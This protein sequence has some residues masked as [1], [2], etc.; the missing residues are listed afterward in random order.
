[1]AL[2]LTPALGDCL[3]RSNCIDYRRDYG[4]TTRSLRC[5]SRLKE[6][7]RQFDAGEDMQPG[8]ILI[9]REEQWA[10]YEPYEP[11]ESADAS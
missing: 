2:C 11:E 5:K 3:A 7:V 9:N 1:V 8:T 4:Y 10:D 6:S